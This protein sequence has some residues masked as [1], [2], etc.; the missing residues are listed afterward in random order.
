MRKTKTNKYL[1]PIII[2]ALILAVAVPA[3]I[4]VMKSAGGGGKVEK[5]LQ[6]ADEYMKNDS[7][8]RAL[9]YLDKAYL[10]N[11]K[12]P[13]IEDMRQKILDKKKAKEAEQEKAQN[14]PIQVTVAQ[15]VQKNKAASAPD[16]SGLETA[17]KKPPE[18]KKEK[19]KIENPAPKET[20]S[21]ADQAKKFIENGKKY[22]ATGYNKEAKDEFEKAGKA[23]DS[24]ADADAI[25][26]IGEVGLN[27]FAP[28]LLN[29]ISARWNADMQEALKAFDLTTA[30]GRQAIQ[31]LRGSGWLRWL[32]S[33]LPW[34]AGLAGVAGRFGARLLPRDCLAMVSS[35]PG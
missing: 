21:K 28:Y 7:Y 22:L 12:D 8:D 4:F 14:R 30:A 15:P 34:L 1:I 10:E 29:R 19:P 11:S 2:G 3:G 35:S 17:E 27:H 26:S 25:P 32:R 24:N 13:R 18:V 31:S 9:D 6:L 20:V 23:D 33:R 5:Y 16:N